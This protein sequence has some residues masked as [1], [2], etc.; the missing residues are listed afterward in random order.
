MFSIVDVPG[1]LIFYVEMQISESFCDSITGFIC[2]TRND[3]R[4]INL[5]FKMI[6]FNLMEKWDMRSSN[7][8]L[9]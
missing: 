7:D 4:R 5:Y 8:F 9:I 6:I 1:K 2:A 3:L